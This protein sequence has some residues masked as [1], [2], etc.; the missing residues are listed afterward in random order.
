[1][2][3]RVFVS[4][5]AA[6]AAGCGA[7]P[8]AD[9][10]TYPIRLGD[11]REKVHTLLGNPSQAMDT[12]EEHPLSGVTLSFDSENRVAKATFQGPAGA[13]YSVGDWIPAD[14]I[15]VFGLNAHADEVEF[16]RVLGAPVLQSEERLLAK[17]EIRRVWKRDGYLIDAEFLGTDRSESGKTFPKGSLLWFNISKGL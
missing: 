2:T 12:L 14:R 10:W 15:I 3:R 13:I 4:I 17:H 16:V 9:S 7:S 1:M 8:G 5:F 6:F 11:D